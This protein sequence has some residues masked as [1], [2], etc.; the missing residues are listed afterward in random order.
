MQLGSGLSIFFRGFE[1]LV[2]SIASEELRNQS[3][4]LYDLESWPI[5][6][7][8]YLNRNFVKQDQDQRMSKADF[9]SRLVQFLFRFH[10]SST[11]TT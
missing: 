8:D 5:D 11:L 2:F 6:F 4:I 1:K 9:E 3:D 10:D 7:R